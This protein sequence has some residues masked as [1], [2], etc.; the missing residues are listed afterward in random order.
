MADY[1]NFRHRLEAVLR[2]LDV[3]QVSEF[4]IAEKQWQANLPT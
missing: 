4:L 3:K 1:P 2:T